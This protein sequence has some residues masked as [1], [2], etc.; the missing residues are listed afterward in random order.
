MNT[1]KQTNI[2]FAP[3]Q[4]QEIAGTSNSTGGDDRAKK[5]RLDQSA[6][7]RDNNNYNSSTNLN[8]PPMITPSSSENSLFDR[9]S[10]STIIGTQAGAT[11]NTTPKEPNE[12]THADD[13]DLKPR[14]VR[15]ERL[16]D[17]ADRYSSHIGF[18]KECRETKVIPKG[19]KIDIEPSIGNN[20]EDFCSQ[21]FRRMEDFSMILISDI[22]NYSEKIENTTTVKIDEEMA[23]IKS[24]MTA[25]DFKR[26]T[27][28]LNYNSEQRRKRL[29]MTKRK[30]YHHL[31]Y[32]RPERQEPKTERKP[33]PE[34]PQG[35][36]QRNTP[37]FRPERQQ[38]NPRPTTPTHHRESSD[39]EQVRYADRN[40]DNTPNNRGHDQHGNYEEVRHT[41]RSRDDA[42][43]S[44]RRDE[45]G[46]DE[47]DV[48]NTSRQV[49]RDNRGEILHY[50]QE[51]RPSYRDATR[52]RPDSRPTSRV[53]SQHSL[54]PNRRSN[55]NLSRGNSRN[56][57][58]CNRDQQRDSSGPA[59]R[60]NHPEHP[61]KNGE[62]PQTG[63]K[64]RTA[65]NEEMMTFIEATMRS[66]EQFKE[67]LTS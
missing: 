7:D 16:K 49:R 29:S 13:S 3:I 38:G 41:D 31:R 40:H 59:T 66:L 6:S 33:R 54:H 57:L 34:R 47:D 44:R 24:K 48:R 20:D 30:K 65:T 63:A 19:L 35:N 11:P 17:K 51:H 27:D 23:Y 15:L 61:P 36:P 2:K 52:P 14:L 18:L 4:P 53:N 46:D 21:W 55:H 12:Y 67:Q 60:G 28:K 56:D 43:I 5:Q 42:T 50:P 37:S 39:A 10:V 26:E 32:N 62:H 1:T 9:D 64:K 45:Y 22:I 8:V 58:R 25:E